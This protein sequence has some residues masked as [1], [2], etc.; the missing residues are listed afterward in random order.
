M[1][2]Q[3]EI[4]SIFSLL[5]ES[6]PFS[7]VEKIELANKG[8]VRILDYL[9]DKRQPVSSGK[10]SEYV[11]ISTARTAVLLR[12]MSNRNLIIIGDDPSD[13]RK[14]LVCISENGKEEL[15]KDIAEL[16][17]MLNSIIDTVGFERMVEFIKTS[18]EIQNAAL[19]MKEDKE[20]K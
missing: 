20:I 13:A 12:K 10:I 11:G 14:T 7:F 3:N 19:K 4:K 5:R 6:R 2:N 1:A 16:S 9:A 8:I 15:N 18:K 17:E